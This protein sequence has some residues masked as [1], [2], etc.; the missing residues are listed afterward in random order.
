[1]DVYAHRAGRGLGPENTLEACALSL[2]YAVHFIDFDIGMTHDRELVVT[3][4]LTLNPAITRGPDGKYVTSAIPIC[5]MSYAELA[6]YNVGQIDPSLPYAAY[7]PSQRQFSV[8]RIP[9]LKEAV[10]FVKQHAKNV[11]FQIEIKIDP[12]KPRLSHSP[13]RIVEALVSLMQETEIFD[14]TEVQSFDYRCLTEI[15]KIAP[16]VKTTYL[17]PS[18][19]ITDQDLQRFGGSY[20]HLIHAL[21]G[22]CWCPFEME[23]GQEALLEAQALGL[24]VV[25]W[26]YPEK[27]GTEFNV[28]QIQK[29]IGWGIDGIIT[30]RPD[31]LL[32]L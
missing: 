20:P 9:R 18:P 23:V 19:S 29:L 31:L 6:C 32:S 24:K 21:G 25:A 27:E 13:K 16:S 8:A 5:E 12:E 2:Q 17:T 30:D 10:Y 11:G 1:M 3:H 4:D 15:Q 28:R 14:K 7:F 22:A 26:G